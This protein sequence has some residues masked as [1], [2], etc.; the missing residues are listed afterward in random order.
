M[1]PQEADIHEVYV[2][3][4]PNSSF[5]QYKIMENNNVARLRHF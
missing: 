5:K 2:G 3:V 4:N 1:Y